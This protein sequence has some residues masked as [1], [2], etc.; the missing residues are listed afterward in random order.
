MAI[1]PGMSDLDVK[2][3]ETLE[4]LFKRDG[5][6]VRM[7]RDSRIRIHSTSWT[8]STDF[9]E[10]ERWDISLSVFAFEDMPIDGTARDMDQRELTP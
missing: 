7:R 6:N 2:F 8:S 4:A 5:M 10:G 3:I 9:A 1:G